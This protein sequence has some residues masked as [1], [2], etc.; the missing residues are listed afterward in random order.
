MLNGLPL[1]G[2]TVGLNLKAY[3]VRQFLVATNSI[4]IASDGS[5]SC[6]SRN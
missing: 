4:F 6:C 5:I 1:F 2:G 3:L